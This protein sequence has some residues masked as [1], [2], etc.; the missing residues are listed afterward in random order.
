MN[1]DGLELTV[2]IIIPCKGNASLLRKTLQSI[3]DLN[4]HADELIIVDDGSEPNLVSLLPEYKDNI[5]RLEQTYGP[6]RARN[7]GA[8]QAKSDIIVFI[9]SDVLVPP[10]LVNSIRNQ[11]KIRPEISAIQGIYT[12][13]SP[14]D[15]IPTRYQNYYY[16]HSFSTIPLDYPAICATYCFAVQRQVFLSLGGFDS[17]IPKPT[18]EDEAFG[19][20]MA[21]RGYLIFLDKSLAVEHLAQYTL[22]Q[23]VKRKIRMSFHQIKSALRGNRPPV[24]F[25]TSSEKQNSTNKTHHSRKTMAAIILSPLLPVMISLSF[26]GFFLVLIAY[27]MLNYSFWREIARNESISRMLL[28]MIV[29]WIDHVSIF[30]GLVAGAID[31]FSGNRY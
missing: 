16:F 8:K 6:A 18:V 27:I 15:D 9:D 10:G 3:C 25:S 2:S 13:I 19:Y 5:L 31:F 28:F 26:S 1:P 24:H 21:S 29:T 11:F 30:S 20:L 23:L 7:S 22:F 4:D 17:N 14:S 12:Q